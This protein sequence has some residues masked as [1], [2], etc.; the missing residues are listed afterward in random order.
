MGTLT[1]EQGPWRISYGG[2]RLADIYHL[3]VGNAI[4]CI[5]VA[6]YDWERGEVTE[7]L[8]G[9]HL[10]DAL[11]RWIEDYGPDYLRELPYL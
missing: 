7:E 5:Q 11:A 4:E 1:A 3:E 9:E 2:G 6:E 8:T 10:A